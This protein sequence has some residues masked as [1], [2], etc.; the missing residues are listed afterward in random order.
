MTALGTQEEDR[1]WGRDEVCFGFIR[2]R[3]GIE[4]AADMPGRGLD[5]MER[6]SRGHTQ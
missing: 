3:R 6:G 5:L 4:A 2:R 1:S